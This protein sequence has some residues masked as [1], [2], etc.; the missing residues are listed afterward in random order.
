VRLTFSLRVG[1]LTREKDGLLGYLNAGVSGIP[2]GQKST[3]TVRVTGGRLVQ[4]GSGCKPSGSVATCA[5]GPGAPPLEFNVMGVPVS[6]T[7]TVTVPSGYTDPSMANN[8]DSVLLGLLR[9]G[10]LRG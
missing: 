2:T 10:S 4:R 7:A 1:L 3:I 9:L 8:H 5:L 6:A